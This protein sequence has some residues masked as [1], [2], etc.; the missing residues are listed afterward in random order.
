MHSMTEATSGSYAHD[1]PTANGY[2]ESQRSK[3]GLAKSD[4][5][6]VLAGMLLPLVTQVGHVH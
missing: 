6:I 3:H 2:A 5:A 1:E 4:I